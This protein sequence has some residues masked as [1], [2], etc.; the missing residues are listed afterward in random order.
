MDLYGLCSPQLCL[1]YGCGAANIDVLCSEYDSGHFLCV[2]P[3]EHVTIVAINDTFSGCPG[4][5]PPT[6]EEIVANVNATAL[7]AH[8]VNGIE[9][10]LGAAVVTVN[11]T[12]FTL[13]I[14][15][16]VPIDGITAELQREIASYFGGDVTADDITVNYTNSKRKRVDN[17]QV[18]V[19]V[20]TSAANSMVPHTACLILGLVTI[21]LTL[22]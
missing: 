8:L 16:T 20:N 17:G 4:S 5:P 15:A 14:N 22:F 2:C 18:S 13:N 12:S 19:T 3:G 6:N 11:G 10:V 9:T 7:E 1:L 21:L